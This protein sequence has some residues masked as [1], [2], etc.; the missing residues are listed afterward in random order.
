[1]TIFVVVLVPGMVIECVRPYY[2]LHRSSVSLYF[3]NVKELKFDQFY[4]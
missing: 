4:R 2:S 3:V 1:M